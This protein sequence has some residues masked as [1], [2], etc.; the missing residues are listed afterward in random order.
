[1]TTAIQKQQDDKIIA[2]IVLHGDVSGLADAEKVRYYASVCERVG[3]DPTTQPFQLLKLNGKE[4]MY[5]TKAAT[6]QLTKIHKVSHEIRDRQTIEGVHI[7]YVRAIGADSRFEDSSGAVNIQGLRGDGL[8]N[9]LMKAETKA[10]RRSTLSLLG[11]GMLDESE[12]ETIPNAQPIPTTPP[13]KMPEVV[14]AS[15]VV[16]NAEQTFEPSPA[17]VRQQADAVL[18][19]RA[20]ELRNQN[21]RMPF[22]KHKGKFFKHIPV[23]DLENSLQWMTDKDPV[24]FEGLINKVKEFLVDS[25]LPF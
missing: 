1:M 19:T 7:V 22:G 24:K 2:S 12:V 3:L 4:V 18:G 25:G 5:A 13:A 10:K 21:E 11:M 17:E 9:A 23:S 6:E 15:T 20:D 8:A 14:N 16:D